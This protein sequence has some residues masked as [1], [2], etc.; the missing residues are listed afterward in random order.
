MAYGVTGQG[1]VVKRFEDIRA[2]MVDSLRSKL[3]NIATDPESKFGIIIDIESSK[4]ADIWAVMHDIYNSK[5]IT[6]E[7]T[8]LD[9]IVYWTGVS[10][11][12]ETKSGLYIVMYGTV[13]CS[14]IPG[15]IVRCK[16]TGEQFVLNS[17]SNIVISNNSLGDCVVS[18]D[19][20]DSTTYSI[21]LDKTFTYETSAG[22]EKQDIIDAFILSIND[23]LTGSETA[24]C[25]DNG[26]E[27]F[28]IRSKDFTNTSVTI[29][30]NTS[31]LS[32]EKIGTAMPFIAQE[33][34]IVTAPIGDAS[35]IVTPISGLDECYNFESATLGRL[36]ETDTEL[37]TRFMQVRSGLGY[38]TVDAITNRIKQEVS[39]V[40]DVITYENASSVVDSNGLPPHSI[41]VVVDCPDTID[42]AVAEKIWKVKAGGILTHGDL[43]KV[44][45]DSKGYLHTVNY[46]KVATEY[47]HVNVVITIS[48]EKSFPSGGIA[49]IQSAILEFGQSLTTGDDLVYQSFYGPVYSVPGIASVVLGIDVTDAIDGTP[50]YGTSNIEIDKTTKV[51]FDLSRIHVSIA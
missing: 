26:D 34:G 21:S 9:D 22:D 40:V 25:V 36:K 23:S 5:S 6:A 48:N 20:A 15:T 14:V 17:A 8:A 49:Q 10:R 3:G 2:E 39:G 38:S 41:M 7:G 27:T 12:S 1:F 11:L 13:G 31:K 51:N 29:V 43:N 42:Q 47:A 45:E 18:I 32:F 4:I 37:R 19:Y 16:E 33:Y 46:S 35:Q 28:S 50:S 30:L 44:V 24:F